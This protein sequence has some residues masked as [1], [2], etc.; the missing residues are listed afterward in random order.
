M[1]FALQTL[2]VAVLVIGSALFAAWRLSPARLKLRLLDAL[3][4]NTAHLWG[5]W[6]ARLRSSVAEEMTQGCGACSRAPARVHKHAARAHKH[7]AD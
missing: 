6:A 1:E 2:L 7:R 3:N 4:P 5:R